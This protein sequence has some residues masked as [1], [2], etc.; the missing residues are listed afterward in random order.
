M[1][2]HHNEDAVKAKLTIT[3]TLFM[4]FAHIAYMWGTTV[5]N[6]TIIV[7]KKY[8]MTQ[9]GYTEFMLV[10]SAGEHYMMSNN[11]WHWKWNN[12]EDWNG[13]KKGD[14]VC[15][16]YYGWRIPILGVFPVI[17]KTTITSTK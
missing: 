17:Y 7:C 15:V 12:V 5:R 13:I 14:H 2:R 16:D 9:N 4:I 6:K 8:Q 1:T 11:I 10:D 3:L